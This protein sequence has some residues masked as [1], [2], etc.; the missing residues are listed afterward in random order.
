MDEVQAKFVGAATGSA[1]TALTMTPF[2][3]VKTRLQTQPAPVRSRPSP[4]VCCQPPNVQCIR[5]MSSLARPLAAE[6]LVCVWDHGL[7]KAEPVTGFSDAV[8]HVW[9]AE[10]VRGLWKGAGTTLVIGVPSATSYML[11]YDHLL[12]NVLPPLLP[13]PVVPLTAGILARSSITAIVSPLELVRTNLQ[14]TPAH[15]ANPNTLRSVLTSVRGLVRDNGVRFLWRGLGPTLWRDVPFSGL[16]WAGY[17]TTKKAFARNGQSGA[18]VAFFCGAFSGTAAALVTNPFDVLK[19]RR[20][21]L[22]M[23][24]ASTKTSSIPLLLRIL[25]TEGPATLFAGLLPRVAK[26]AP[27]CGIMIACY[28]GVGRFLVKR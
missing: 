20:Q 15:P 19:T 25:R 27:A 2:D 12:N 10:G 4:A 14:S 23:S 1:M 26:I 8:R 24:S 6:H 3:V 21:A 7:L 22:L 17:E 9:R 18:G 28:E 16:Y 13:A 11:T 5:T